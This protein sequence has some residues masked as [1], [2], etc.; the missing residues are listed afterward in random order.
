MPTASLPNFTSPFHALFKTIPDYTALRIFGCSCFPH[1][2]P[3]N[4][5][6]LQLRSTECVYLGISPQHK[7]YKCLSSDGHIY[8]SKDVVFN[9]TKFPYSCLVPPPKETPTSR[10]TKSLPLAVSL[11]PRPAQQDTTIN[12]DSLHHRV[13]QP[14]S[15]F[16]AATPTGQSDHITDDSSNTANGSIILTQTKYIRDLLSRFHME[17]ANGVPSPMLSN[18][19]LSKY[20]TDYIEDPLQ[21]RSV[22]GAL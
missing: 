7:G 16:S 17:E 19:K 18:S 21:Y 5:H 3:Y 4:K 8:I 6:K 9:E 20:G 13:V 1:L 12:N 22:V 11:V 15:P 10:P 14:S 2:R